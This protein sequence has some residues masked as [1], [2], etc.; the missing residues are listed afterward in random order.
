[1]QWLQTVYAPVDRLLG[2]V[3]NP[4][5]W[6]IPGPLGRSLRRHLDGGLLRLPRDQSEEAGEGE[7]PLS[8][9]T[10]ARLRQGLRPQPLSLP[11]RGGG[12][13]HELERYT[14][15]YVDNYLHDGREMLREA[16]QRR[17]RL[18]QERRRLEI[19]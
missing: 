15:G 13:D 2:Q 19:G 17:Q 18:Q 6:R 11:L 4:F 3:I 10:G 1:V 5:P 8:V 14:M 12:C 7:E 16:K 9:V